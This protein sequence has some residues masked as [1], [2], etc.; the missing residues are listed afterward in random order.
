MSN[1]VQSSAIESA[2]ILGDL[3]KLTVDQRLSY[4]KQVCE[5]VGLNPLT[6]PFDYI[7]LNG[8]LTLYA[9]RDATDQL[10][11]VHKVSITISGREVIGEIYV[12]TAKAKDK[13]GREDESTG[14]VFIS[15]LKGDNLAN[16]YL[17]AE[18]KA[19]RR[20]TL[21]ICGLGLL[22]ETEVA[23]IPEIKAQTP[24]VPVIN[25][26]EKLGE[27]IIQDAKASEEPQLGDFRITFGK[28]RGLSLKEMDIFELDN[29]NKWL[30]KSAAESQGPI[31]QNVKDLI[32]HSSA[33]LK[34]REFDRDKG[35]PLFDESEGIS[36]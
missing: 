15:G 21:S 32:D 28:H 5:S 6:K 1:V 25:H 36:S 16:A 27:K 24:Q 35:A 2:L 12:V 11:K 17:K 14:A 22:D 13:D 33:F 26:A 18:T 8:K 3:S 7:L 9:K 4:Y 10:R 20:V 31:K 23:D 19:K 29:Y 30:V 34:S